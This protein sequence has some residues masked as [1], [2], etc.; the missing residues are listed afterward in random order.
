[1]MLEKNVFIE[2]SELKLLPFII[3][4]EFGES[5]LFHKLHGVTVL[6]LS[7]VSTLFKPDFSSPID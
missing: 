5:I 4:T 6:V 3:F 7:G 1:M 2:V